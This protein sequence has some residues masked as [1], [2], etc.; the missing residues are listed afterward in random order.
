MVLGESLYKKERESI[1]LTILA[2]RAVLCS[3]SLNF[4]MPR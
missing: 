3:P 2:G 4:N 1:R